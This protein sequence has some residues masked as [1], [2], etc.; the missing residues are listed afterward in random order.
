MLQ[1]ISSPTEALLSKVPIVRCGDKLL[2]ARDFVRLDNIRRGWNDGN[3]S[4]MQTKNPISE[5]ANALRNP[6]GDILT[7]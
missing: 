2:T 7:F 4:Y 5:A 6:F 1:L 3:G